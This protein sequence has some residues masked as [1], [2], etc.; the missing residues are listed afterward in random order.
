M[1]GGGGC[2]T[3]GCVLLACRFCSQL[4][5][6]SLAPA[7]V[8][9]IVGTQRQQQRCSR[10]VVQA[11]QTPAVSGGLP[12]R[13]RFLPIPCTALSSSHACGCWLKRCISHVW[14]SAARL[15]HT[16]Q[17]QHMHCRSCVQRPSAATPQEKL[18]QAGG[19]VM[20]LYRYP[21]LT[22]SKAKTLLRKVRRSGES[23]IEQLLPGMWSGS[24]GREERMQ[25]GCC[26]AG[27]MAW[28]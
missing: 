17:L 10:S 26:H 14:W 24:G 7:A 21:G 20:Q 22:Q 4:M 2:C 1:A 25:H 6:A 12:Q 15:Q 23:R 28:V 9:R 18:Q 16:E 3:C 5:I 13:Q 27:G 8:Q 11:V 19:G